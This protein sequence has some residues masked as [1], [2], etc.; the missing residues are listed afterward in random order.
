MYHPIFI[1]RIKNLKT[2]YK[3]IRRSVHIMC[4]GLVYM[5]MH[6]C[7]CKLYAE[8]FFDLSFERLW[9]RPTIKC[10]KNYFIRKF[11]F[12]KRGI[13]NASLIHS[14]CLPSPALS[15]IYNNYFQ[16]ITIQLPT[17]IVVYDEYTITL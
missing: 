6:Y 7:G 2:M 5:R 1:R 3:C 12:Y 11:F 16:T 8:K 13:K 9:A 10:K 15:S 4:V 17:T 14:L